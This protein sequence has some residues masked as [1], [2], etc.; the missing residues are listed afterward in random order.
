MLSHITSVQGGSSTHPEESSTEEKKMSKVQKSA[1]DTHQTALNSISK[2]L[3]A[4]PSSPQGQARVVN[5]ERDK[6]PYEASKNFF[7]RSA[8]AIGSVDNDPWEGVEPFKISPLLTD[9]PKNDESEAA[10]MQFS[11]PILCYDPLVHEALKG[12]EKNV[13]ELVVGGTLSGADNVGGAI[14]DV[15]E[16]VKTHEVTLAEGSLAFRILLD[17]AQGVD[18]VHCLGKSPKRVWAFLKRVG[19]LDCNLI[20]VSL[21][22]VPLTYTMLREQ[23]VPYTHTAFFTGRCL[24]GRCKSPERQLLIRQRVKAAILS[25]GRNI[26][27]EGIVNLVS[28]TTAV[29]T[30]RME[31]VLER[32]KAG[33][34]PNQIDDT[35][36]GEDEDEPLLA[37][38]MENGFDT[39][40]R[41]L[42]KDPRMKKET[43]YTQAWVNCETKP[44]LATYFQSLLP[45]DYIEEASGLALIHNMAQQGTIEQIQALLKRGVDIS[46]HSREK[47]PPLY[48]AWSTRINS[49]LKYGSENRVIEFLLQNKANPH[50]ENFPENRNYL[51]Q[52]IW[53]NLL[54]IAI[55]IAS[56]AD[57]APKIQKNVQEVLQQRIKSDPHWA[58]LK[59]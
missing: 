13:R 37:I 42:A 51:E 9:L 36:D 52:A 45:I 5:E 6:I 21:N 25:H 46:F 28:L 2:E 17:Y 47:K 26:D 39:I 15:Y 1:V 7:E 41:M 20:G 24:M 27:G 59:T 49:F 43:L 29:Q 55:L 12:N 38:A 44:E 35:L 31:T 8:S 32:L 22:G 40:A 30:G 18:L 48:Y 58:E 54:S 23:D 10:W 16:K 4:R 34:D 57:R 56:T 19:V 11:V 3:V 53:E 14:R 33:E 50:E